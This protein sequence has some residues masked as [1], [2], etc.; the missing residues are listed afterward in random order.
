MSEEIKINNE[1]EFGKLSDGYKINNDNNNIIN[2]DI[3]NTIDNT[4]IN[5]TDGTNIV[6]L[7]TVSQEELE[8][9]NK[10]KQLQEARLKKERRE[11]RKR[12]RLK[13]R[14]DKK[15]RIFKKEI[16]NK[17]DFNLMNQKELKSVNDQLQQCL[18]EINK[19]LILSKR[20]SEFVKAALSQQ[21]LNVEDEAEINENIHKF[22]TD[23]KEL[24][25]EYT[26]INEMKI[27]TI[28]EVL[29]VTSFIAKVT[30]VSTSSATILE[31]LK[32]KFSK[33]DS[34]QQE[35]NIEKL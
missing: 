35:I 18:P 28:K 12:K 10:L 23:T 4:N 21:E 7:M 13:E 9:Q 5:I 26:K 17:E 19:L 29:E 16:N 25:N 6:D 33:A 2:L 20:I 11:R 22:I 30:E 24:E 31:Y 15:N 34:L 3:S 1:E 14:K 8:Q 27:K 32:G